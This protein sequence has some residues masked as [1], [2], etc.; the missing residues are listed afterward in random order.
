MR[1]VG[2]EAGAALEEGH[3]HP[4]A[5]VHQA[6]DVLERAV[7]GHQLE[8]D[9]LL[10]EDL[11]VFEPV[12]VIVAVGPAGAH[13]H[14]VRRCRLHEVQCDCECGHD[15][16]HRQR[17]PASGVSRRSRAPAG[18]AT[19][20]SRAGVGVIGARRA[21]VGFACAA[22]SCRAGGLSGALHACQR[23]FTYEVDMLAEDVEVLRERERRVDLADG[24][25]D[26]I[27]APQHR[28]QLLLV[29]ALVQLELHLLEAAVPAVDPGAHPPAIHA[30]QQAHHREQDRHGRQQQDE[31]SVGQVGGPVG[32]VAL[33]KRRAGMVEALRLRAERQLRVCRGGELPAGV[34]TATAGNAPRWLPSGASRQ[35][36]DA[37]PDARPGW[38]W[39]PASTRSRSGDVVL[40]VERTHR[41]GQAREVEMAMGVGIGA[42]EAEQAQAGR[43]DQLA[44]QRRVWSG[45]DERGIGAARQQQV[46]GGVP[47]DLEQCAWAARSGRWIPAASWPARP[48]PL[49]R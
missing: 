31:E 23:A 1:R 26:L 48:V 47:A 30:R 25:V 44:D 46:G 28:L 3:V 49:P 8:V 5:R 12:A 11:A 20:L 36:Q 22:C 39:C 40:Q 42:L 7:G 41:Q 6:P 13:D 16:H 24:L 17:H 19:C 37:D 34:K 18:S 43:P 35:A 21:G 10:R 2:G 4:R 45:H 29:G 14:L 15:Q 33:E 38:R 32:Q 27:Q 9:A